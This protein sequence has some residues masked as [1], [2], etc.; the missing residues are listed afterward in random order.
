MSRSCAPLRTPVGSGKWSQAFQT[1][2]LLGQSS[3][4]FSTFIGLASLV[5]DEKADRIIV[6]F[7][8][9]RDPGQVCDELP[10]HQHSLREQLP[11]PAP[12]IWGSER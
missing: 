5:G 3:A 8:P 4:S 2:R 6:R 10:G 1:S 12:V 7:L 9:K 11:W